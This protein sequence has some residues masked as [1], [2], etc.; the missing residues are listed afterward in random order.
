MHI[1]TH[2]QFAE[3]WRE[4]YVEVRKDRDFWRDAMM[5]TMPAFIDR[6]VTVAEVAV[7]VNGHAAQE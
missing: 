2:S 1:D 7:K 3:E 5:E 4:K 6:A